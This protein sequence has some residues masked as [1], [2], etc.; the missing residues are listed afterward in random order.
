VHADRHDPAHAALIDRLSHRIEDAVASVPLAEGDDEGAAQ[1]QRGSDLVDAGAPIAPPV[2][3]VQPR[4]ACTA[5][6]SAG[7]H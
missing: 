5:R 4:S 6:V 2:G 3:A 1:Q 7:G